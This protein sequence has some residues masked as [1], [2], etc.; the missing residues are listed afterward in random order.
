MCNL[1]PRDGSLSEGLRVVKARSNVSVMETTDSLVARNVAD[2]REHR[3]HTVRSLSAVLDDLGRRILPSGIS[4]IENQDRRVDASDLVALSLALDVSPNRLLL[5]GTAGKRRQI[6]LTS[7]VN[8]SEHRAWRWARGEQTLF[9]TTAHLDPGFKR[10]DL[11]YQAREEFPQINRPD[12]E[13]DPPLDQV[14][15][16][17]L[18]LQQL[19]KSVADI[20]DRIGCSV[21]VA[22]RLV[23]KAEPAKIRNR[24]EG[25]NRGER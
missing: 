23:G 6:E 14:G 25:A 16:H 9:E 3:R 7:R 12:V 24:P 5:P 11:V 1:E 21:D 2:L 15:P 20:A 4:K 18:E 22:L 8:V 10:G 19:R 13:E 17:Y